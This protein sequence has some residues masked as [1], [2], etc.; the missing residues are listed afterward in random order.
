MI[1]AIIVLFF[2]MKI[3]HYGCATKK[4]GIKKSIKIKHYLRIVNKNIYPIP[5]IYTYECVYE[6]S[7]NV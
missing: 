1:Y 7:L 6:Y 5:S 4:K 2:E 3:P